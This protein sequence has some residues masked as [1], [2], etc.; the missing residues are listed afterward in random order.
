[1]NLGLIT[2]K[3]NIVDEFN[4]PLERVHLYWGN[5]GGTT[6]D[7]GGNATVT[8]FPNQRVTISYVGKETDFMEVSKLPSKLLLLDKM[9]SLDEVVITSKPKSNQTPNYVFPALGAAAFLLLLMSVGNE[10]KKVVL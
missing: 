5:G 2:R 1:M 9:E 10:P 3:I 8:A 6:T 7:R 4:Q